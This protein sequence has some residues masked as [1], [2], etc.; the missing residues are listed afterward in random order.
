L[1]QARIMR[2]KLSREQIKLNASPLA[3]NV[4]KSIE[5]TFFSFHLNISEIVGM[6]L[7]PLHFAAVKLYKYSQ[8]SLLNSLE[9]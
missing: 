1:T 5:I 6:P 7:F 4:L 2:T 9:P 3:V 8:M